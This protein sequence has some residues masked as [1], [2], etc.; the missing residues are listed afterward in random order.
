[1]ITVCAY[2][3]VCVR[4]RECVRVYVWTSLWSKTV[5]PASSG[6][7]QKLSYDYHRY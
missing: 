7:F 6:F 2:V 4:E 3:C 1:M 5:K